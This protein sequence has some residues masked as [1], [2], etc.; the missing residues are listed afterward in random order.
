MLR[1]CFLLLAA[2]TFFPAHPALSAFD[3]IRLTVLGTGSERGLGEVS[4]PSVMV[5]AGDETLL[6][7]CGRNTA[8]RLRG[9]GVAL[10]ELTAVFITSLDPEHTLGCAEVL[11]ARGATE[12]GSALPVWGPA[13]TMARAQ[14]WIADS[15]TGL[16]AQAHDIQ[17]N[18]IYR[19]EEIT[20]T[21]FVTDNP[22]QPQSFGY[23]VDRR[24]RAVALS[25]GTRYS[26]DVVRYARNVQVLVHEVALG[27]DEQIHDEHIRNILASHASPE[28]AGKVFRTA[29]PY[30]A[31][32]THVQ[33][34]GMSE[35]DLM[36]R[37]RRYYRGPLELAWELMIIEIQNE[38]QLRGA[39]SDGRPD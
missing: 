9:A 7:D 5:E 15:V 24:G 36:R 10:R 38:V 20:V 3:G 2:L 28:D 6:F 4:G 30:L 25:G 33:L 21:A 1:H 22:L 27:N 19:T 39:P 14:G 37:T 23:R 8:S 18:V 17:E 26:E 32:Y 35:S 16:P 34:F 13:G 29:R 11:R 12:S 31:V